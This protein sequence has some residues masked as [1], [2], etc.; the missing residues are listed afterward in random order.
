MRGKLYLFSLN[1]AIYNTKYEKTMQLHSLKNL[2]L[3]LLL[4]IAS[5]A[6]KE[7]INPLSFYDTTYEVPMGGV[8]YIGL[9]NG[10]GDY[11]LQIS[12]PGIA[13]AQAERGW[14][15]PGGTAIYVTGVLSGLTT[16]IVTDNRTL[17]QCSLNIKVVDHYEIFRLSQHRYSTDKDYATPPLNTEYLYLIDNQDRDAYFFS[18]DASTRAASSDL[19]LL[20]KGKYSFS[21]TEDNFY[22]TLTYQENNVEI[23]RSYL[24]N[25]NEYGLH[26]LDK[27][28]H[29]GWNTPAKEYEKTEGF[30]LKETDSNKELEAGLITGEFEMPMGI[31]P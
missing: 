10:N 4:C 6:C 2:F 27:Y 7:D 3:F 28:L 8:R 26:R 29:L 13:R 17:E 16:L 23:S 22:L 19:V 14:S 11:T 21:K 18:S 31:L 9:E 24:L 25:N 15:C 12:N 20:A 1:F 30:L 5:T